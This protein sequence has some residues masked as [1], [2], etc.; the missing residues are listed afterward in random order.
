MAPIK[1]NWTVIK[2]KAAMLQVLCGALEVLENPYAFGKFLTFSSNLVR[3]DHLVTIEKQLRHCNPDEAIQYVHS[4]LSKVGLEYTLEDA[5]VLAVHASSLGF[6]LK[7]MKP[8]FLETLNRLEW[9][10]TDAQPWLNR[11]FETFETI[12]ASC[13]TLSHYSV[14][15]DQGSLL[16]CLARSITDAMPHQ[17]DL[18][19]VPY[20]GTVGTV[21][22]GLNRLLGSA[23]LHP[24]NF[25]QV[26]IFVIG[27]ITFQ[28][29][30]VLT[31]SF[32]GA[33]SNVCIG[34]TDILSHSRL[35][36]QLF[37][38]KKD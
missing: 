28:E 1:D 22:S 9:S 2:K 4:I 17:D 29:I 14:H 5:V 21:L 3:Y 25:K 32:K 20:S 38:S 37:D 33:E 13:D 24:S 7:S 30:Q 19:H 26:L 27:G 15:R 36:Q 34:S 12:H 11:V 18:V 6:S 31:K 23:P 8:D 35:Y 10:S 16:A